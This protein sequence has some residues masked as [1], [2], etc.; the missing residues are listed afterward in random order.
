MAVILTS[1]QVA[2]LGYI[3]QSIPPEQAIRMSGMDF[4]DGV[5]FLAEDERG[6]Q[7]MDFSREIRRAKPDITV[8][9]L[10]SQMYEERARS[11]SAAEGMTC[12]M[13][14]AK[15]NGLMDKKV[16]IQ[17]GGKD[18]EES[19]ARKSL[20]AI[21]RQ[22]DDELI[23]EMEKEG[24]TLDLLPQKIV[25]DVVIEDDIEDGEIEDE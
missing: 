22:T 15:I 21:Q 18:G 23:L 6:T 2:M 4:D 16:I 25:R 19:A 11:I 17:D 1:Q 12:L 8:E 3:R 5:A 9:L 7:A 10:T 13:G 24:M 14:I 20:K